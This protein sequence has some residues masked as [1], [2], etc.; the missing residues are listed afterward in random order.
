[1]LLTNPVSAVAEQ[2]AARFRERLR[3]LRLVGRELEFPLVETDG[4]AGDIRRLWPELLREGSFTPKYDDPQTEALIVSLTSAN[5]VYEA[6]VGLGTV[7]LL[8]PA[9]EDLFQLETNICAGLA[10]LVRAAHA[11]GMR[12]L[13]FG[14]QPRTPRSPQLMTPKKRYGAL[15]KAIGKPW[16]HFCTTAA[17]QLHVDIARHELLPMINWM[18][19]ISAPLVALAANSSVYSGR[20]GR[21]VSGRE[22]LL[23]TVGQHR[24]GMTPR[25]FGSLEEFVAF[26]C[27]HPCYVL[28]RADGRLTQYNRPFHDYLE[29][30]GPDL[31]AYLW[32]EHYTWN[33][34]RARVEQSTIEIRPACQQPPDEM[35]AASA[36]SLG[37][38]EAWPHIE[39]YAL[40]TLGSDPWPAMLRY[41]E[42]V[43]TGG[44][45]AEE[46]AKGFLRGIVEIAETGLRGRGRGE[47]EYLKPVWRRLEKRQAPAD[48]ARARFLNHGMGA[49]IDELA[50][51]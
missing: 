21:F 15:L 41:R 12:V 27:G 7:E 11:A 50:L 23:G 46:P 25:R 14:I 22:G 32:H 45:R 13:G 3:P 29:Q 19:F 31:A 8:T 6:E 36:L 26:V 33:S 34:A 30:H 47:E 39:T 51:G 4:T 28:K 18:N 44:M 17:D 43:L 20:A 38:V 9:C 24:N 40:R 2:Y 35:M 48:R 16:L 5:A 42:R 49:L 10:P 1:M 37:F